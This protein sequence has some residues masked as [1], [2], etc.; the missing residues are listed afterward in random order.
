MIYKKNHTEWDEKFLKLNNVS[1][2]EVRYI[3]L[4]FLKNWAKSLWWKDG[5]KE[6]NTR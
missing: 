2:Y 5:Q 6:V 3:K 4:T 1:W